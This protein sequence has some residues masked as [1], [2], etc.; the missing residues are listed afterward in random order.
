MAKR[1]GEEERTAAAV[2]AWMV[3]ILPAS[4]VP[5]RG[6]TGRPLTLALPPR[7]PREAAAIA[8]PGVVTAEV[9]RSPLR[10]TPA[11]LSSEVSICGSAVGQLVWA[12]GSRRRQ[13]VAAQHP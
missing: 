12:R 9:W 11:Q 6:F 8:T 1:Q 2:D 7:V 4:R 10:Q 3:V 5:P 13:P